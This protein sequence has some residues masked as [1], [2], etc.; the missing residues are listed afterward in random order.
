MHIMICVVCV[1]ASALSENLLILAPWPNVSTAR[2]SWQS[3]SVIR[4]VIGANNYYYT[5][6]IKQSPYSIIV[7]PNVANGS[8]TTAAG[9]GLAI[10]TAGTTAQFV[11]QANDQYDNERGEVGRS[12][13][14]AYPLPHF[15]GCCQTPNSG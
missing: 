9:D 10:A 3:R 15:S 5:T 14:H 4:E 1:L 11:I 7:S 6:D 8:R 12:P 13:S 2:R